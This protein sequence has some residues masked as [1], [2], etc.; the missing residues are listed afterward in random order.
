[1]GRFRSYLSFFWSSTRVEVF[2]VEDSV[3]AA[4]PWWAFLFQKHWWQLNVSWKMKVMWYGGAWSGSVD[5]AL[6]PVLADVDYCCI[7]IHELQGFDCNLA[8]GVFS[9]AFLG[10]KTRAFLG[11]S[12]LIWAM[13]IG[14]LFSA[15]GVVL[16][17]WLSFQEIVAAENFL[18]EFLAFI[19]L[20]IDH[21]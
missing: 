9:D 2:V 16:L 12:C 10:S 1:M 3:Q 14:A 11:G 20:R 18:V 21:L 5:N 19:K 13:W 15:S 6:Y 17:S 4:G 8:R 7:D